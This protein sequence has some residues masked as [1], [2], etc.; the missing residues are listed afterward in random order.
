MTHLIAS[1]FAETVH[2]LDVLSALAWDAGADVV[3]VRIDTFRD[4]LARLNQF[5]RKHIDRTWLITCR[6]QAE[7]GRFPGDGEEAAFRALEAGKGT[8]VW[9]D[10]ELAAWRASSGLRSKVMSHLH[11][12]TSTKLILS[13]H[14]FEGVPA[15]LR[16]VVDEALREGPQVVAKIAYAGF[17]IADGFLALDLMHRFGR[18]V[19]A[20]CMGE[21]GAWTRVMAKKLG[22]F[23][24]IASLPKTKPTAPGQ[25]SVEEVREDFHWDRI[26]SGTKVF[27]VAG[28][29]IAHSLSPRLFNHWFRE[30][31]YEAVFVPFRVGADRGGLVQFLGECEARPWLAL[32]GLSVTIPHKVEALKFA[33]DGAD[34]MSRAIGAANTL[35]LG[36]AVRAAYNTDCYA[37]VD[38]LAAAL[39]Q[40]TGEGEAP[41]QPRLAGRL[42]L[43]S[44]RSALAGLTVDVLGA[45]GAA[46]AVCYGLAEMGCSITAF[47]RTGRDVQ[48]FERW[49][50]VVR[51]WDER[52]NSSAEVL[53]NC[54][55]VGMWP[56]VADSPMP[57]KTL[58]GRRL[59]FDLIYRPPQ[60][61]LLAE[62]AAAGRRTLSGLDMFVRQAATQFAL[63]TG[64]TPD[65][66]G[67]YEM[68]KAALQ[69]EAHSQTSV[70]LI[71]ARGSG[72]TTVGALLAKLLGVTHVDSDEMVMAAA[73]KSIKE[74]F[75]TEG[76]AG[77]RRRESAAIRNAIAMTPAVISLGGGAVLD[78]RNV[79]AIRGVARV[80]WLTAPADVLARRMSQDPQSCAHR[81]PLT[82]ADPPTDIAELIRVREPLY[83][84]A[85]DFI[86]DTSQLD[87]AE[88]ARRIVEWIK[89]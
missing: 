22:A 19:I 84:T 18:R 75:E 5:L 21:A 32:S 60:T 68:L 28:D 52:V 77:F 36:E 31:N 33:G 51:K 61:K 81:P 54:T 41:A 87:A 15:D 47:A 53:V 7:G 6:S 62:A 17:H 43:P 10:V 56:M 82:S 69:S 48:D 79:E 49:G 12:P 30:N 57:A 72:K 66:K 4:D 65:T 58:Q 71:G 23:A 73:G 3:E 74:I 1:T 63:W 34:P 55:P 13:G 83:R 11:V 40:S 16:G 20:I 45:G 59:V 89:P 78:P 26:D 76:E 50:V 39:Q 14:F 42:A 29:P 64:I 85:A 27:G 37:A 2:E 70:A 35:V 24:T 86:V 9:L 25:W 38:S 88:M 80:V 44:A 67:A 8:V 46:R